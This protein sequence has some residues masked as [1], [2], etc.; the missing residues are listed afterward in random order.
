M[1]VSSLPT[2]PHHANLRAYSLTSSLHVNLQCTPSDPCLHLH[3]GLYAY[4]PT[5]LCAYSPTLCLH[6]CFHHAQL[7]TYMSTLRLHANLQL[8]T[9][10]ARLH[11][12]LYAYL[13]PTYVPM[14]LR[15]YVPTCLRT[16]VPT[17]LHAYYSY[18]RLEN[19]LNFHEKINFP[20]E[21]ISNLMTNPF[22]SKLFRHVSFIYLVIWKLNSLSRW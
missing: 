3:T 11:T 10:S 16:Y 7:H 1:Y 19:K 22:I 2:F 20:R 15:I 5:C 6:T 21:P 8:C 12:C 17:C 9:F 4:V 13:M 18:E 14:C